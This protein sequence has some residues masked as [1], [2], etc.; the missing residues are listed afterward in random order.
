M[1]TLKDRILAGMG[2][3]SPET[4]NY[5]TSV[6]QLAVP[7]H[8]H[9]GNVFGAVNMQP[10]VMVGVRAGYITYADMTPL[11]TAD[12]APVYATGPGTWGNVY[13]AGSRRRY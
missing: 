5:H 7:S 6:P 2:N 11:V 3:Y 1:S 13:R 9:R 12:G 8:S 10:T 4:G